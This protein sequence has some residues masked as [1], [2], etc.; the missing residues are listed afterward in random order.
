M[1]L[2]VV[3]DSYPSDV[4]IMYERSLHGGMRNSECDTLEAAQKQLAEAGW[5]I[6]GCWKQNNHYGSGRMLGWR[7]DVKKDE[8]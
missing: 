1:R 2:E 7:A 6:T 5:Y 8:R 3:D 4:D